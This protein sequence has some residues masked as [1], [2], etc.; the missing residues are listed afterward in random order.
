MKELGK[1]KTNS[2][3]TGLIHLHQPEDWTYPAL[4]SSPHSG[5]YYSEEFLSQTNVAKKDLRQSEDFL[6]DELF[7]SALHQGAPMLNALFPRAYCDVNRAAGELDPKMYD[8]PLP[9]PHSS[10]TSRVHAGLGVIPRRVHEDTNLYDHLLPTEEATKRLKNCYYPYHQT[11]K[12]LLKIGQELFHPLLLVDCHSMPGH[13]GNGR[14]RFYLADVVLGSR[15]RTSCP[16]H[17]LEFVG[18][19]FRQKGLTVAFDE[20]YAGGYITQTYSLPAR[21]I[22]TLQIEL[23]R[24]LY[25]LPGKLEKNSNFGS[26]QSSVEQVLMSLKAYLKDLQPI[27]R[28]AE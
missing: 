21:S 18:D 10:H 12:Q 11:L 17:L 6:V 20:P 8:G 9:Q 1:G 5:N 7:R 16:A 28:A 19:A 22:F 26:L 25:M 27:S 4:F 23:N 14:Q 15:F 24:D 3:Q 2:D 13:R